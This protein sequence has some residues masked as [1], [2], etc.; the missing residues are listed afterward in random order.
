MANAKS[1]SEITM[2]KWFVTTASVTIVANNFKSL[3]KDLLHIN[4]DV[5]PVSGY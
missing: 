1:K 5:L 2:L 4:E 3:L